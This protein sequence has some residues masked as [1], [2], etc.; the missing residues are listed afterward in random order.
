MNPLV[1][2]ASRELPTSAEVRSYFEA[3]VNAVSSP[4]TALGRL[5]PYGRQ[6]LRRFDSCIRGRRVLDAGA[7]LGI[8]A[9]EMA[10]MSSALVVALD[11]S[12]WVG[13]IEPEAHPVQG[14]LMQLPFADQTFD[15]VVC[16]EVLEHT[17]EPEMVVAEIR[18]VLR[19]GGELLLSTPSY[20]NVAGV[21]KFVLETCRVY[22]PNTFAPFDEWKP[23]VLERR[24]TA[25]GVKRLLHRHGFRIVRV[26]GA[27]L[28]DAMLPFAN[29]VPGLFGSEAFLRI[30]DQIDRTSSWPVLKW[31]S[32]HGVFYALR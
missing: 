30:R 23:K 24:F 11:Y 5:T 31:L 7:G 22:A 10:R 32:L 26:E 21:L 15:T 28:F 19:P 17:L 12:W 9:A 4:L 3:D 6:F 2:R 1:C 14:D 13:R 27:E 25:I 20:F 18:R 29:R 16:L 8:V